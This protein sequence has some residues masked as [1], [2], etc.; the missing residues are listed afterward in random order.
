[1]N[2]ASK[3]NPLNFSF[4]W[5]AGKLASAPFFSIER[6]YLLRRLEIRVMGIPAASEHHCVIQKA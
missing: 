5:D 3:V 4:F 6:Y 2:F 1:M